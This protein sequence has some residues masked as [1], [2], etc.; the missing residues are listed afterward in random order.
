MLMKQQ[1]AHTFTLLLAM[2]I[3]G[4]SSQNIDPAI[5][6]SKRDSNGQHKKRLVSFSTTSAIN[7][8]ID[9]WDLPDK[10]KCDNL[11]IREFDNSFHLEISFRI[12]K[13]KINKYHII[14]SEIQITDE[15]TTVGVPFIFD[16]NADSIGRCLINLSINKEITSTTNQGI[17]FICT[18]HMTEIQNDGLPGSS[19]EFMQPLDIMNF[20]T[21][22]I[23]HEDH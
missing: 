5:V 22:D 19:S 17:S 18:G 16:R 6:E 9:R 10:M 12:E 15:N 7:K 23:R 1:S 2:V 11:V 8:A 3:S 4:C 21:T 13:N 14:S 20:H